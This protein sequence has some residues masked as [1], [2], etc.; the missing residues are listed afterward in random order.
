MTKR[1]RDAIK[2]FFA[3]YLIV[4]AQ[5]R[6]RDQRIDELLAERNQVDAELASLQERKEQLIENFDEMI[7][8]LLAQGKTFDVDKFWSFYLTED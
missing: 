7:V 4:N 2:K 5:I 8:Q 6:F 1:E 3:E